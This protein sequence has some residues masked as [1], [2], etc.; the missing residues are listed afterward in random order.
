MIGDCADAGPARAN[1]ATDAAARI[2]LC[3]FPP[4][5]LCEARQRRGRD[6]LFKAHQYREADRNAIAPLAGLFCEFCCTAIRDMVSFLADCA[7][8]ARPSTIESI[9]AI[10]PR[11]RP[12]SSTPL[13]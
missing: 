9:L 6:A 1:A 2:N 8:C 12:A 3:M 10:H 7:S 11:T 5:R 4:A 13:V